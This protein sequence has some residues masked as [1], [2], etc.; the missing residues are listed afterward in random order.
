MKRLDSIN[1]DAL[2]F[3]VSIQPGNSQVTVLEAQRGQGG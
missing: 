2:C 1:Q 3:L